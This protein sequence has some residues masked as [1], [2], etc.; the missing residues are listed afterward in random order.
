MG[1]QRRYHVLM[2][3][4]ACLLALSCGKSIVAQELVPSSDPLDYPSSYRYSM[5]GTELSTLGVGSIK[6]APLS[7]SLWG[8]SPE[9][10]SVGETVRLSVRR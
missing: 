7:A 10:F 4:V 6:L 8:I 1:G 3:L 2:T 5:N 9:D